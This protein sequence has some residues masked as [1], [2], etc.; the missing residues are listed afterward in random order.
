MLCALSVKTQKAGAHEGVAHLQLMT[1]SKIMQLDTV[2]RLLSVKHL[3]AHA[4]N[5]FVFYSSPAE[6]ICRRSMLCSKIR[7]TI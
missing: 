6:P 5:V 7:Q 1:D 3:I 4:I 2:E